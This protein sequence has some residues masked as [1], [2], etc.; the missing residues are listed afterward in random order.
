L[1]FDFA[2]R[3]DGCAAHALE[4]RTIENTESCGPKHHWHNVPIPSQN[5]GEYSEGHHQRKTVERSAG[6]HNHVP[7]EPDRE[8]EDHA[9]DCRGDSGE[10]RREA[11]M[12][13]QLFDVRSA[14]EDPKKARHERGPCRHE[15]AER[16]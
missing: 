2:E 14:E 9:H 1:L 15:R 11:A 3:V 8:I 5:S 12:T 7:A 10:R 4:Q 16:C 6:R 13:V